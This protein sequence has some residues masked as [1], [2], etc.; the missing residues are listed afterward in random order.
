MPAWV[1]LAL[2]H[3]TNNLGL[4]LS[5][6]RTHFT[7]RSSHWLYLP[8][9]SLRSCTQLDSFRRQKGFLPTH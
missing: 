5:H 3:P 4:L 8:A 6:L 1:T 7:D 2:T 9:H